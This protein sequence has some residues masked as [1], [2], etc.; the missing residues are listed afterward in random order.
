VQIEVWS[1]TR[2]EADTLMSAVEE[3]LCTSTVLQAIEQAGRRALAEDGLRGYAKD[4]D[5][6][7]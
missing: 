5:T 1:R 3:Q 6:W 4:F 7:G 2:A